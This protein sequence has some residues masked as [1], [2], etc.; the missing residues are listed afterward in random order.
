MNDQ[1]SAGK[2]LITEIERLREAILLLIAL[3][4]DLHQKI[5]EVLHRDGGSHANPIG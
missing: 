4:Q 3:Q 1:H 2:S 5:D